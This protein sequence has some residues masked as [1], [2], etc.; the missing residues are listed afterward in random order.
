M[1]WGAAGEEAPTHSCSAAWKHQAINANT[2][3]E[4][5][6]ASQIS[7]KTVLRALHGTSQVVSTDESS[8]T[9]RKCR[10][11][12]DNCCISVH[13]VAASNWIESLKPPQSCPCDCQHHCQPLI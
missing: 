1:T 6:K 2:R 13:A 4:L 7:S 11:T 10:S 9:C 5:M 3:F 12:I 8:S